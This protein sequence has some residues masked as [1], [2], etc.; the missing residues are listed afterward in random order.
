MKLIGS[1][2]ITI[3]TDDSEILAFRVSENLTQ[4]KVIVDNEP[5]NFEFNNGR[6][7]LHLK[8]HEQS[9]ELQITILYS[10]IFDDPVPVRPVNTDN[11]GYGVTGTI[12]P[13]GSIF[14]GRCRMVS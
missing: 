10:G 3:K 7:L 9:A 2:D 4:I 6:L 14:A 12:S 8:P 5:R 1:D 11:P 13:K